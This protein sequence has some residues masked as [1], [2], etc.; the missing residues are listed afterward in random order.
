MKN[1]HF[2]AGGLQSANDEVR[3]SRSS[4]KSGNLLNVLVRQ[5][6]G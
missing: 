4:F 3:M 1:P 2:A 5:S 6:H